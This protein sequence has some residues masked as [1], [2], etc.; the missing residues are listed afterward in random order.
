MNKK[1]N[2]CKNQSVLKQAWKKP[3]IMKFA[4]YEEAVIAIK[5]RQK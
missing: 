5:K 3:T 4:S 2:K 1:E